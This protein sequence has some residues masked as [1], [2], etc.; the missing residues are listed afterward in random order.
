V[1]VLLV[2]SANGKIDVAGRFFLPKGEL[3]TTMNL[4]SVV[5]RTK[6]VLKVR[7]LAFTIRNLNPHESKFFYEFLPKNRFVNPNLFIK[8]VPIPVPVPVPPTCT[9]TF[10]RVTAG[11][12]RTSVQRTSVPSVETLRT[13]G[14]TKE[15]CT[16]ILVPRT[17]TSYLYLVPVPVLVPRTR[18][19][20]CTSYLHLYL[21]LVPFIPV[22][23]TC[24]NI[25]EYSIS[26]L[27]GTCTCTS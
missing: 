3:A 6:K 15:T 25:L 2:A 12:K 8:P 20:T 9:C 14:N 5:V 17:C 24:T 13:R 22:P 1:R 4:Q 23:R 21:Y 19:C 18:T 27:E 26:N 7:Y 11:S 16:C 10:L